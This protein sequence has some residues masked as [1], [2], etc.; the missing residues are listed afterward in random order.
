[1]TRVTEYFICNTCG[2]EKA[3]SEKPSTHKAHNVDECNDCYSSKAGQRA[4]EKAKKKKAEHTQRII[5][6]RIEREIKR[7]KQ[8]KAMEVSRQ[9]TKKSPCTPET[10]LR[11]DAMEFERELKLI[12]EGYEL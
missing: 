3:R 8:R 12:N 2:K 5:D 7:K 1:M 11:R 4:V 10:K 6:Q 9:P